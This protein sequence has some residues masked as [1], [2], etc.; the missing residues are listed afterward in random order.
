MKTLLAHTLETFP[1]QAAEM[2]A[3]QIKHA[4]LIRF[5]AEHNTWIRDGETL[6]Q[7]VRRVKALNECSGLVR[8][9]G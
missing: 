2:S 7:A 9:I 4:N 6:E 3:D 5:L 1:H 8:K